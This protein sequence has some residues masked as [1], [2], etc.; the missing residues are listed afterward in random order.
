MRFFYA[1][2]DTTTEVNKATILK[3]SIFR[4]ARNIQGNTKLLY[5]YELSWSDACKQAWHNAKEEQRKLNKMLN[6]K[7]DNSPTIQGDFKSDI[8]SITNSKYKLVN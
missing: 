4:M 1:Y 5:N 3:D 8:N 7:P 6:S 2:I